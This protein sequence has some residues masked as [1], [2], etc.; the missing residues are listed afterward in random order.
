MLKI[1]SALEAE[2]NLFDTS[3]NCCVVSCP[4]HLSDCNFGCICLY[5]YQEHI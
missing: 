2:P 5:Y 4:Q 1:V 3:E